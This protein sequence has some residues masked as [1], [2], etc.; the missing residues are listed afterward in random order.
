M[1]KDLVFS[2]KFVRYNYFIHGL[3]RKT[4]SR[5]YLRL[6]C[7]NIAIQKCFVTELELSDIN[8]K[9]LQIYLEHS[10]LI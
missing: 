6:L 4:V 7:I 3:Q 2:D 1:V 9:F 8:I 10:L 5:E